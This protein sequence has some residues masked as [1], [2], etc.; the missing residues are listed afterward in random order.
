MSASKSL[1]CQPGNDSIIDT[2]TETCDVLQD[3]LAIC[4][5]WDTQLVDNISSFKVII[6]IFMFYDFSF[7]INMGGGRL[8]RV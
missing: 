6:S 2:F 5:R 8:I 3:H 7:D 4:N 1:H